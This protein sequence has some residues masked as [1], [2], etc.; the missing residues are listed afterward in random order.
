MIPLGG[1]QFSSP[2]G[3]ATFSGAAG[4]RSMLLVRPDADTA[5]YTEVRPAPAKIPVADYVGVYASD[6]L[7]T[8]FAIVARDGRLYL[9]RRP[10]EEFELRPVYED[11]FQAGGGLGTIRFARGAGGRV[12]GFAFYAGRVLDVRF[13]RTQR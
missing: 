4:R 12:T 6:E 3:A 5:R 11:D 7:E 2:Q 10:Y 1:T 9:Q 8:R 13:M